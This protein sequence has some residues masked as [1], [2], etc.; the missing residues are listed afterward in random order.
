MRLQ[1]KQALDRGDE[2]ILFDVRHDAIGQH[3][4]LF[5]VVGPGERPNAERVGVGHRQLVL[6]HRSVPQRDDDAAPER[7]RFRIMTVVAL[8]P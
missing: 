6:D 5:H 3:A 2:A 1:V 4:K 8:R 7:L